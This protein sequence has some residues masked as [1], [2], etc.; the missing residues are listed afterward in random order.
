MKKIFSCLLFLIIFSACVYA[1]ENNLSVSL[2]TQTISAENVQEQQ[3]VINNEIKN[4]EQTYTESGAIVKT[5]EP[6]TPYELNIPTTTA[7]G[8]SGEQVLDKLGVNK[9]SQTAITIS[10]TT[11]NNAIVSSD[12]AKQ[13]ETKENNKNTKSVNKDDEI[14]S[15]KKEN[16]DN[17][18]FLSKALPINNGY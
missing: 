16:K 6:E 5:A 17:K 14:T 1:Q 11:S 3:E 9:S 15:N 7:L 12:T 18:N 13:K 2:S 8:I 4:D 10:S